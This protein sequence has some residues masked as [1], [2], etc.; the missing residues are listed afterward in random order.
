M[1]TIGQYK[2]K[3]VT[4]YGS[5]LVEGLREPTPDELYE[6]ALMTGIPKISVIVKYADMKDHDLCFTPYGYLLKIK[7]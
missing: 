7:Q 1:P 3:Y 5:F 4:P 2:A 6:L